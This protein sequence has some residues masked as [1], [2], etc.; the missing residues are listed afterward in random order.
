MK[1]LTL[2]LS[3]ELHKGLKLDSVNKEKSMTE[4]VLQLIEGYLK[5]SQKEPKK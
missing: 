2:N 5:T 4:I 1:K 3:D